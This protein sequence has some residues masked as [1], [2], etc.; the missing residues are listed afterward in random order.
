MMPAS[1]MFACDVM[2]A[3]GLLLS[4]FQP[5]GV[6]GIRIERPDGSR[7]DCGQSNFF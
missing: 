5:S 6:I 3:A 7:P 2:Q 1:R 4:E